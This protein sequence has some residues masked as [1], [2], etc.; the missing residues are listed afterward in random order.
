MEKWYDKFRRLRH[1]RGWSLAEAAR[2][3][4]AA[5]SMHTA[6]QVESIRQQ[7][8][9]WERG[10]VDTP[11][12]ETQ[13]AVAA[14]F[15]LPHGD[16]WPVP[17]GSSV[18]GRLAPDE[19]S[20][21]VGAFQQSSVDSSHLDQIE[22]QIERLCSEYAYRDTEDLTT[23][24]THWLRTLASL[25]QDGRVDYQG[26]GQV[27]RQAGWLSLLRACLMYDLGDDRA[28]DRARVGAEQLAHQL[29]DTQ[30]H[31]WTWEV[32]AWI[33]LTQGDL[34]QAIS[35]AD[36]GLQANAMAPV[37]AQL[38]AQKAKAYARMHDRHKTEVELEHVRQVLDHNPAPTNPRNHF[39]VDPT[40]AS[41][42]AMDSY[43]VLGA[44]SVADSL[45]ES[46]IRSSTTPSGRVLSPMRL[47]E[48]QLTQS[49]VLARSG[50]VDGASRLTEQ[51]LGHDR[52]SSPSLLLV[53]D[54]VC[55]EI[56]QRY[57]RAGRDLFDQVR[58]IGPPAS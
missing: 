32:R 34:L 29:N 9:R 43:R 7:I 53:A 22:H 15:D 18:P 44:N 24:T 41:F 46:V 57:P 30:M 47:A 36:A 52:K 39:V 20:D 54:E 28:A 6:D 31:A 13:A 58:R 55:R 40:K 23:E 33:A 25:V 35:A 21:L 1:S 4:V 3:F 50:D 17:Q 10:E 48:A 27:L 8:I 16:F 51:A 14:M 38:H 12:R 11:R 19:W 5:S 49:L 37:A 2:Q 42:Y 45:A 26:H 56:E